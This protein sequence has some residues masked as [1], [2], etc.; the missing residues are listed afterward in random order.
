MV[1][2]VSLFYKHLDRLQKDILLAIY[3]EDT[4]ADAF[5]IIRRITGKQQGDQQQRAADSLSSLCG[6][7]PGS[8][9]G[10]IVIYI[11]LLVCGDCRGGL[12]N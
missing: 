4:K 11:P 1:Q 8:V 6:N 3:L 2:T 5:W 7:D 12:L 9:S 10:R